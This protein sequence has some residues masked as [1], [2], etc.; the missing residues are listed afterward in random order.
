MKR[1]AGKYIL[2]VTLATVTMLTCGCFDSLFGALFD[3][4]EDE[5]I[6]PSTEDY[7]QSTYQVGSTIHNTNNTTPVGQV[8]SYG[9]WSDGVNPG[10]GVPVTGSVVSDDCLLCKFDAGD[11]GWVTRRCSDGS[12]IGAT[13]Y[14]TESACRAAIGS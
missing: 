1:M 4:A 6:R 11:D 13:V 7:Q 8:G 3:A 9:E 2:G 12:Q 5:V 14:R 10:P